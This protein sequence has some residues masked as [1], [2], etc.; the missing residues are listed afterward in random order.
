MTSNPSQSSETQADNQTTEQRVEENPQRPAA[1]AAATENATRVENATQTPGP[2]AAGTQ[3]GEPPIVH[4]PPK[5]K[6][7]FTEEVIGYAKEIRGTILRD[8]K[9]KEE[10]EKILRGEEVYP[11]ARKE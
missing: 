8:A 1:A 2:Q 9:T 4:L 5:R 6:P 10:G 7:S 3:A 11:P